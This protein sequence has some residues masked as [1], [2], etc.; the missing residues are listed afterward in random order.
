MV[1]KG[2]HLNADIDTKLDYY[3]A[4]GADEA[5]PEFTGGLVTGKYTRDKF[6]P[7]EARARQGDILGRL[8]E[9]LGLCQG[10]GTWG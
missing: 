9:V 7:E 1:S 3:A 6:S 8:A 5:F 4:C 10:Y 2:S